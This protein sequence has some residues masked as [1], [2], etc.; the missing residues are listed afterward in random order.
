[1]PPLERVSE[2][3]IL[4]RKYYISMISYIKSYIRSLSEWSEANQL[5][6]GRQSAHGLWKQYCYLH[7]SKSYIQTTEWALLIVM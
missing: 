4:K 6:H 7:I 2:W 1:M 5:Q 3:D